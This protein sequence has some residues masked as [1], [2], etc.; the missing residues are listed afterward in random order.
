MTVEQA[1]LAEK[2]DAAVDSYIELLNS[3]TAEQIADLPLHVT[4]E[5]PSGEPTRTVSATAGR[6]LVTP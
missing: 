4:S 5:K 6:A 1:G 3:G 2:I